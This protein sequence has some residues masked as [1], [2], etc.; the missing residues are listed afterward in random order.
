ML[1]PVSGLGDPAQP[2]FAATT[3]LTGHE[4]D[5]HQQLATSNLVLNKNRL[6]TLVNA[7]Q[8]EYILSKINAYGDHAHGFPLSHERVNTEIQSSLQQLS[9]TPSAT[10]EHGSAF[11]SLGRANEAPNGNVQDGEW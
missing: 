3:V 1:Q 9:A 5:H 10:S 7:I 2:S 6:A 8:I 4:C 11:Y